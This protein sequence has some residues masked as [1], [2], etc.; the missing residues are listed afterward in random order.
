MV[1]RLSFIANFLLAT[2]VTFA[3][4][5]SAQVPATG[6]ISGTV[7]E[8]REG[9][10][11]REV[12]VR[13]Q[14]TGQ[15]VITD[16]Q[17]R[18]E[19]TG[20]APGSHE[21]YVSAVDFIL[22]KRVVTVSADAPAVVTISLTEGTG[23][24][25]ETV[26]VQGA[27]SERQ[28]PDV[29]A[30]ETI[31]SKELQQLRGL[32]TNDPLRAIQVMPGVATGDDLRSEFTVRGHN[33][34]HMQFTFDGVSTP[35][36]LHTVQRLF[37]TGSLSMVNGDVLEE[38]SLLNGAYPQRYGNRL[39]AEIDFRMRQG[40]RERVQSRLSVSGTDAAVVVEGPLG[41][42]K[43]GSW[44]MSARK[45]Y[46][47]LVIARLGSDVDFA[48]GFTDVQSKLVYD[49]NPA[50]QFQFSF[51]AG[52]SRLDQP[53]DQL[54]MGDV[55]DGRN[56]SVLGVASWRYLPSARFTLTQRMAVIDNGYSNINRDGVELARGSAQ[57][58]LYRADWSYAP[59]A[60]LIFEGGGEARWSAEAKRDQGLAFFAPRFEVR[61]DFDDSA[62]ATSAYGQV[63]VA[64]AAGGAL[65]PGARI[66]HS[67]LTGKTKVSPWLQGTW[68]LTT[69]VTLRGGTGVYRQDPS[70]EQVVG[71]RGTASLKSETAYHADVGLE[72]RIGAA[73]SWQVT[74]YNREERDVVTLPG[75]WIRQSD[76]PIF[77]V[78]LPSLTSR[79]ENALSGYARGVEFLVRRQ[80]PNGLSGWASYALGY[81]RYHDATTGETFWGNYDQRHTVNLYGLY[82]INDRLSVGARFRSGSN[83]PA[84]GY[85][86][87]RGDDYY[88]SDRRNELRV[89][90]YSRL[91]VRANRTFTWSQKRLTLFVEALNIYGRSNLRMSS[92]GVDIR[93][94]Q[95]FGLF[96]SLFPFVP[97]AGVLL[98]F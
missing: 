20:V 97:S 46:L 84:T 51:V 77:K 72:G 28:E 93:T 47:D 70:F 92:P 6:T 94:G 4:P 25:T 52:R 7:V 31:T 74:L 57:D 96:D 17:G 41:Q 88:V 23:T 12:A 5:A 32:V 63:R 69:S 78:T 95:A 43:R 22:V 45:S 38:V 89:P 42:S 1:L 67:T 26:T 14:D 59:N 21:L 76:G 91:D 64:R 48:F 10:P 66:D 8:T 75:V 62:F 29:A 50:N 83:F 33:V 82:R 71:L 44:L 56:A 53:A 36:L 73:T 68:P 86:E 35:L 9:A 85:W 27:P 37:D 19:F 65:S 15:T 2:A 58:A 13:L 34:D 81:S 16:D 54:D 61:E 18:F 30:A 79:F 3:L 39:G 49:V 24:F 80:S 60:R 55:Q 90:V 11:V 87:S 98:E 40:S